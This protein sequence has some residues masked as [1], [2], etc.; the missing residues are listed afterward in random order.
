MNYSFYLFCKLREAHKPSDAPY[1]LEYETD[2]ESYR[3]YQLS[4]FATQD[5]SEYDC[6]VDFLTHQ[7]QK[8]VLMEIPSDQL[9]VIQKALNFYLEIS[10]KMNA[11]PNECESYDR[12]DMAQLSAMLNYKFSVQ[13]TE[14]EKEN[15]T[16]N[17]GIDLPTYIY[18]ASI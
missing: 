3:F 7:V 13:F 2:M 6:I 10:E 14:F 16:A 4:K 8:P 15:F 5:K 11:H 18:D 12:F 1:D 17:H 9:K